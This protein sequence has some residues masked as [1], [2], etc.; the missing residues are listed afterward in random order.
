MACCF[1]VQGFGRKTDYTDGRELDLDASYAV[2]K[3]AVEAAGHECLRAD[4]IRHSG[5]I[6]Q[7]MYEHLLRADLVIAD[8]ST[9]N[10]NAAFE[11]GVRYG[12]RPHATIIVAEEGFK[13]AFDVSHLMIRR[14][15]HLG[16]DIGRKEAARFK[17]ELQEAMAEIV[18]GERVD[19][20]VYTFLS[21]LSPPQERSVAEL[22]ADLAAAAPGAP[23]GA[24]CAEQSSS[25][26]RTAKVLLEVALGWI[27]AGQPSDFVGAR[28]LLEIL[29][30]QRPND[31][32]VIHQL[33]LATYRSEQPTPL[34]ALRE[35]REQLSALLPQTTND[36]ETLSL[37]GAVHKRLW[38]LEQR[39][40]DL[41]ESIHA[42]WR[43]FY[44]KQDS[45]NG[46]NLAR[47]LE[48]RALQSARA[49]ARDEAIADRVLARRVREDV[50]RYIGPLL[51]DLEELR[52]DKRYWV[53]ASLWA[54]NAGLGRGGDAAR[55][56]QQAR[57]LTS[58][59][60]MV[61]KTEQHIARM[62]KTQGELEAALAAHV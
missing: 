30:D 26:S 3:E 59:S 16:E 35:A 8:L 18:G 60:D 25:E 40:E 11:L 55:W 38:S 28:V 36:P 57:A 7:P 39:P 6:D 9:Q 54:V 58:S 12:L 17:Q 13:H 50:L 4:E 62:R 22:A 23:A 1:V 19:S 41:S 5:T 37:W 29:R 20:P 49:G 48:V 42:Y 45:Y 43:G 24:G 27:A 31:R 2:I 61:Q 34:D 47:L 44:V 51:E 21:H 53:L 33:A 52:P 46:V 32:F 56:E 15:K 14:Y 10:M